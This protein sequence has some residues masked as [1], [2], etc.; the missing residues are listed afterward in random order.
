VLSALGETAAIPPFP[1]RN[2]LHQIPSG[3]RI[4]PLPILFRKLGPADIALWAG[5]FD[6]TSDCHKL[7]R[8]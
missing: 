6:S 3:R 2:S 5:R 1:D 4:A 8:N 7:A